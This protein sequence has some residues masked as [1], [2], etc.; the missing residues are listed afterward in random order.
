MDFLR[1]I[2]EV[3]G[4]LTRSG[5]RYAL[6][7]GFAMALRGVQ[8][9]TVDLDFILALE[10]LEI[11]D[12]RLRAQGYRRVFHSEN[13][14]HYRS[15]DDEFGRIDILHAFRSPSL[16]MLDRAEMLEVAP[17]VKLPVA[18][19]ED[20]IGLKIQAACNDPDR[21]DQDWL[22]IRHLLE[23]AAID[24]HVPDWELI[25]QYLE[26]FGLPEKRSSMER[27]YDA[28]Q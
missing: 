13:V 7:G 21:S 4:A 8:R 28:A 9:A 22:D 27:W 6:I 25:G 20:I 14:S 10:D 23:A 19:M 3:G 12:Q 24:G 5:V 1:V 17:S 2:T 11:A 18:R 16:S 26:I 15:D